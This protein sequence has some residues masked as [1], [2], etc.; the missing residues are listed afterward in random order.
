MALQYACVVTSSEVVLGVPDYGAGNILGCKFPHRKR[1]CALIAM[2][3]GVGVR[4][5]D[6]LGVHGATGLGVQHHRC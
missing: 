1:T 2:D 4:V 6:A 3:H 5:H